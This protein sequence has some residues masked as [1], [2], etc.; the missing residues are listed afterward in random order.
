MTATATATATSQ[1]DLRGRGGRD[2]EGAEEEEATN[3]GKT[4]RYIWKWPVG[5]ARR[6]DGGGGAAGGGSGPRGRTPPL[7]EQGGRDEQEQQP[8]GAEMAGVFDIDIDDGSGGVG[9]A[10]GARKKASDEEDDLAEDMLEMPAEEP[11]MKELNQSLLQDPS[12]EALELSERTVGKGRDK[13]GPGDF[14]LRKVLGKG[15]YG[16]V[17][18]VRKLTGEDQGKIFAMKVSF[19]A[20]I[21]FFGALMTQSR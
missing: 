10:G 21:I 19:V 11:D 9:G 20:I 14:E 2:R 7:Q 1:L 15:G 18:Q 16:K 12:L 3:A 13:A 6:R 17:F 5:G 8:R 4:A